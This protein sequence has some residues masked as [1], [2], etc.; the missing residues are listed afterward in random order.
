MPET[1]F[2]PFAGGR[3][4]Q[5]FPGIQIMP[6]LAE[7]PGIT[8]RRAADHDAVDPKAVLVIR[9]FF[10]TVDIAIAEDR[11]LDPGV[12]FYPAYEG[13]VRFSFVKLTSGTAVNGQ[14]LNAGILETFG[15]GFDV[16]VVVIPAQSGLDGYGQ[17][18]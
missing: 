16:L 9:G 1:D 10:G 17:V 4:R 18:G 14:G 11:D 15:D 7:D 3:R 12:V 13:P 5:T 8:D 2:H 6:G